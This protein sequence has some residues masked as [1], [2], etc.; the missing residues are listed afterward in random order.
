MPHILLCNDDG[1]RAQGINTLA[2]VLKS[3]GHSVTIVAPH[4]EQSGQSH[5]MS[6]FTPVAVSQVAERVWSVK[7]TPADCAA[8]ALRDILADDPP[9]VVVSGINHG[10]NVGWDVHYSGTV[11]AATEASFLGFPAVAVSMHVPDTNQQDAFRDAAELTARIVSQFKRI[12]WPRKGVLNINHPGI[13]KP[14]CVAAPCRGDSLYEPG[15]QKC[16]LQQSNGSKNNRVYI[17]G[18]SAFRPEEGSTHD[19]VSLTNQKVATLTF[20]DFRQ[21][22]ERS[23]SLVQALCGDL[24]DGE[25]ASRPTENKLNG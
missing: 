12:S 13:L 6:F 7:G 23:Q 4:V 21:G 8:I 20:L 17:L 24:L 14:R 1:Y 9:D 25:N 22:H 19:D 10:Y 3:H 5:A 16:V 11:G 18:G 15:L 2:E